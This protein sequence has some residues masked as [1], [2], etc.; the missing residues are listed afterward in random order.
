M[1]K[2]LFKEKNLS[3]FFVK[4]VFILLAI[5][6]LFLL[7]TLFSCESN[8]SDSSSSNENGKTNNPD[9]NNPPVISSSSK[10]PTPIKKIPLAL[11]AGS[12]GAKNTTTS[13]TNKVDNFD[14][15]IS[16]DGVMKQEYGY[17]YENSKG[18]LDFPILQIEG[19]KA[20]GTVSR[21]L[22]FQDED[23]TDWGHGIWIVDPKQSTFGKAEGNPEDTFGLGVITGGDASISGDTGVNAVIEN[24]RAPLPPPTSQANPLPHSYKFYV[25]D[26]SLSEADLTTELNKI[27]K[28]S[29]SSISAHANRVAKIKELLGDKI[30]QEAS[31]GFDYP[32]KKS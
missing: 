12:P 32:K 4:L 27:K 6:L 26:T 30:L 28:K 1:L 11:K 7:V 31:L 15:V 14:V 22:I 5:F 29:G 21:F 8:S 19:D 10:A 23:D 13:G 3:S 18:D 24:Y 17:D 2:Y 20:D 16:A 9:D 25:F